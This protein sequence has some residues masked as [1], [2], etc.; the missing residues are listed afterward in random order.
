MKKTFSTTEIASYWSHIPNV[1]MRKT[2]ISQV[3]VQVED[4]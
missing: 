1:C 4:M 2:I 3:T